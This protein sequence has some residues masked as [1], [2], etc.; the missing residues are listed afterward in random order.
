MTAPESSS[1]LDLEAIKKLADAATPGPWSA[2]PTGT[3]CADAD[4]VL[5]VN[6]GEILPEGGPMEIAECYRNERPDWTERASNAAFIAAAR[7]A[8]PA[9]LAALE[10]AQRR[11]ETMT[12][13]ARRNKEHVYQQT[14]YA[15]ELEGQLAAARADAER[16]RPVLEA[17]G[18][19]M[20]G[21]T[22]EEIAEQENNLALVFESAVDTYESQESTDA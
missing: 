5:D 18:A 6:G 10:E 13:V 3:V 4:L 22:D 16:M 19:W 21:G 20:A 14:E 8:V 17:V 12:Y 2:D 11:L 7:T 9:L 1:P 15:V